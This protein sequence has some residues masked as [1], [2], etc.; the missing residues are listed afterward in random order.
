M[1]IYKI[2][3]IYVSYEPQYGQLRQRS[4][5]YEV[6]D[7]DRNPNIEINVSNERMFDLRSK[8][9]NLSYEECEY[10]LTGSDFC[11]GLLHFGGMFLHAS[12]VALDGYAYLFSAPC[13]TGKSTHTALW[14]QYFGKDKAI[15]LNDDKP[16][17]RIQNGTAL[18]YGTPF[19]GKYDINENISAKLGGICF[20]HQAADNSI[21]EL[22]EAKAIH[23]LMNQS[24]RPT[25]ME[26]MSKLLDVVSLVLENTKIYSMGCN[27]SSDAVRMS[28]EK[29]HRGD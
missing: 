4:E 9:P 20:L 8:A 13:G 18:V 17:I 5:K 23:A 1:S 10:L 15:I 19:S 21:E 28:Y 12:A 25:D 26:G 11:M 3:D 24:L 6:A 14:Q 16:A 7:C 29:M 27:I 2:A 22:S